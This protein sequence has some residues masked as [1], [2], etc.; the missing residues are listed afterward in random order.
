MRR[1][2]REYLIDFNHPPARPA[3]WRHL[4][5]NLV[6]L[7]VC[8]LAAYGAYRVITDLAGR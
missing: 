1:A 4:A 8:W 7:I 2:E 5:V 3:T 6:L